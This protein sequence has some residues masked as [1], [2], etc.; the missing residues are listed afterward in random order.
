MAKHSPRIFTS[1]KY[2][3]YRPKKLSAALAG[4][5]ESAGA[6][7]DVPGC[8]LSVCNRT[9]AVQL[10]TPSSPSSLGKLETQF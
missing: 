2:Y 10:S 1:M 3:Q 7:A 4:L 9:C 6:A 8:A 5:Y